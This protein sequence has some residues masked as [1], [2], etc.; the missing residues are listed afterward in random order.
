MRRVIRFAVAA[1]VVAGGVAQA[2]VVQVQIAPPIAGGG[3]P[4]ARPFRVIEYTGPTA[5]Q[6]A[7]GSKLVVAGTVSLGK[8]T[9]D[10]AAYPGTPTKTAY[11]VATIKVT[12]TLIGDK[13]DAVKVLIAPS[14]PVQPVFEYPGQPQQYFPPFPNQIQV[15]DGQ[16]GVFFL[17]KHPTAADQYTLAQGQPPLSPLDTKYKDDLAAVKQM[18]AIYADPVKAL[19][20][21]KPDDR[22]KAAYAITLRYRQPP[23]FD[24][25]QPA[26]KSIPAEE[27]KLIFQAML[28]ADWEKWDKPQQDPNI[29]YTLNPTGLI[30]LI[31][32]Y[33]GAPGKANF[34]QVRPQPNQG[35]SAA[36]RDA[37]KEWMTGNGKEFEIKRFVHPGEKKDEPKKDEPKK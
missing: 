31:G 7:M 34:P 24:G 29:D 20:A 36:Y 33:A 5:T 11:R 30:G 3:A 21:E 35:F 16:E 23:P 25:K 4:A 1:A 37:F 19:K 15:I 8:E 32:V 13:A 6:K 10:L 14:D 26:E 12:D 9:V 2:Q 18:A 22:M 17:V 28:D 27:T